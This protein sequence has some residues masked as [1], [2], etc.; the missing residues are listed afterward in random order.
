MDVYY[1]NK[2]KIIKCHVRI[3]NQTLYLRGLIQ[4]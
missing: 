4:H 2:D 3:K 1:S